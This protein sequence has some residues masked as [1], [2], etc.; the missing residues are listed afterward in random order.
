MR[1]TKIRVSA[2]APYKNPTVILLLGEIHFNSFHI[3][4]V[5]GGRKEVGKSPVQAF[6]DSWFYQ[7]SKLPKN[8]CPCQT[9]SLEK[10][11]KTAKEAR[12][13]LALN[14]PRRSPKNKEK[15]DDEE[16]DH[17]LIL[18]FLW[19]FA[20]F[21]SLSRHFRAAAGWSRTI[22]D[23][24]KGGLGLRGV[25]FMTVFAVLTVLA[26]LESTLPSFSLSYKIQCQ[27]T[28]VKVLTVLAVLAVVAVSVVRA[29]PLKLNPPFSFGEGLRGN[30]IRGNRT[31]SLWEGNLPLR[32]SLRG[33]VS[34]VFRGFH[35]VFRGFQRFCE[36]L[37]GFQRPSQRPSQSA[38][39]LSELRVVLPL[40]V[41]PLKTPTKLRPWWHPMHF[42]GR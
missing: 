27:E 2:P 25:A 33:R 21:S 23:D 37:R 5:G 41:L 18:A 36:V 14:L 9:E 6:L 39:F 28:T 16:F 8:F 40:I 29:T 32:G 30:T 26:V 22:Q 1:V 20:K 31:E 24:E 17:V 34:E 15:K 3:T 10:T 12:K 4:S 38:V 11:K 7:S 42:S 35:R 13:F 19:H